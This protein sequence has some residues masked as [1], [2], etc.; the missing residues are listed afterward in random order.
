MDN[1]YTVG[2]YLLD[3]LAELGIKHIFGVPGDY[4]LGFI[5]QIEADERLHWVANCNELNAAYAA[6]GYGRMARAGAVVVTGGVGDLSASCGIG[7]ALAERS[8]V[9]FISGT[10][11][12][13]LSIRHPFGYLHHSF[14]E[15]RF[16]VFA[17][18]MA[19]MTVAHA[20][21]TADYAASEIDRLLRA[22]VIEYGPVHLALPMNVAVAPAQPPSRPLDLVPAVDPAARAALGEL[23]AARLAAASASV[24]L[25]DIGVRQ[26]RQTEHLHAVL[27]RLGIPFAYTAA[28]VSDI[29]APPG[30]GYLGVYPAAYG[31]TSAKG[32]VD[33]ADAVLRF[34][35]RPSDTSG[36]PRWS[37]AADEQTVDIDLRETR[38]N[39]ASFAVD[40]AAALD[41]LDAFAAGQ[42]RSSRPETTSA[43][44]LASQPALDT[45][46]P[47][48]LTQD[49]LFYRLFGYLR[50]G[51]VVL[52]DCGSA[53]LALT[54]YT[55]PDG[56]D[57]ITSKVW[58]A[59][60]Y[61]LPVALGAQLAQPERRH[62]IVAGD[63]AIAMT[64]QE[65]STLLREGCAPLLVVLN[66]GQYLSENLAVGRRMECNNLWVWDYTALAAGFDDD[67]AHQPLALR[68]STDAE[69]TD[70]LEQAAKAQAEG[71]LAVIDARLGHD[72]APAVMR[73]IGQDVWGQP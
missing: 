40:M 37:A 57:L 63:G 48:P 69:L 42:P 25:I 45:P 44:L 18:I 64:I 26:A 15:G 61:A 2:H 31:Q 12:G 55:R 13:P 54:A 20:T 59:I 58:L 56:V 16:D 41:I 53:S 65:L 9:V 22:C 36:G 21:L 71:R 23:L 1:T 27:S 24:A 70:A 35:F 67:G 52:P 3:R 14:G 4:V 51:D 73:A 34:G 72:D 17:G 62:I 68:A 38:T 47:G 46:E 50:A 11:G 60:G 28:A 43:P 10:P 7:G 19:E 6:E 5:R 30:P 49:R 29:P 39:D 32:Q 33:T 66:N 8:P